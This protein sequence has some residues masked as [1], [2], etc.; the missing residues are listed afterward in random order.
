LD[1]AGSIATVSAAATF[2]L[3]M[4]RISHLRLQ[5]LLLIFNYRFFTLRSKSARKK[6]LMLCSMAAFLISPKWTL[7]CYPTRPPSS[8]RF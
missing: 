3:A 4:V 2:I 1:A 5:R 6:R 7:A 8:L